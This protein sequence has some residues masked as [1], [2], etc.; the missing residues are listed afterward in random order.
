LNQEDSTISP[1]K[2]LS[3]L[4]INDSEIMNQNKMSFASKT[5]FAKPFTLDMEPLDK[6]E[7]PRRN[8]YYHDKPRDR[9]QDM[10]S[11]YQSKMELSLK[12]EEKEFCKPKTGYH[13]S[14]MNQMPKA[15]HT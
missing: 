13:S 4:E 10:S 1:N 14:R 5:Y 11:Y 3:R 2:H 15:V 9:V 7:I 8:I 6:G 12:K